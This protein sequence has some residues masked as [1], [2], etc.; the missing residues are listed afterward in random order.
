MR[1]ALALIAG[2]D[3][4]LVADHARCQLATEVRWKSGSRQLV[5]VAPQVL[6]S[7]ELAEALGLSRQLVLV[8]PQV[9]Q[10]GELAEALGLSCQLV[11]VAPKLLQSRELSEALELSRQLNLVEPEFSAEP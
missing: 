10:R 8:A 6:E 1:P 4:Q 5:P 9:L 11:L 2:A 7:G 3:R